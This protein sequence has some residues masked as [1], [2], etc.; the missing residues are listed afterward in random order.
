MKSRK[1]W[2]PPPELLSALATFPVDVVYTDD[3]GEEHAT[4]T[5]SAPWQLGHGQHVVMLE[6]RSGGFDLARVRV[7]GGAS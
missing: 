4:R 5:R 7:A 3:R 2:T 6:G 1:T